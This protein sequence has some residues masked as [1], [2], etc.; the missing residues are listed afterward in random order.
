M[1]LHLREAKEPTLN[2]LRALSSSVGKKVLMAIT[3]LLLCGFLITHLAGNLLMYVG[4]EAYNDYA[5]KLHDNEG[6]LMVAETGLFGIF[7]LH[8][9]LALRVSAENRL[10]RGHSYAVT[11]HKGEGDG[12]GMGRPDTWMMISGLIILAYICLHLFDFKLEMRPDV[13]Y[14]DL[15]PYEKAATLLATPLTLI[16][17]FIGQLFLIFHLMHG[18]MSALQSLG[19]NHSKYNRLIQWG[20]VLFAFAIGGGFMSFLA[21]I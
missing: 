3:G 15:T 4:P 12:I 14:E 18:V 9:I 1:R 10:A 16:G 19:L 20:S 5:H 8:I 13:N 17:Y 11:K 7:I 6:L 21:L 2:W